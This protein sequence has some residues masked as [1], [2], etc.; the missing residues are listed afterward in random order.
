[1]VQ[2]G[3]YGPPV[4]LPNAMVGLSVGGILRWSCPCDLGHEG[5]WIV[6]RT[7]GL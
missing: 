3:F 2:T 1:M 6:M 4:F 7:A 5:R